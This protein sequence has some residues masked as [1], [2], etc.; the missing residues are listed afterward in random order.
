MQTSK[1]AVYGKLAAGLSLPLLV[2]LGL[3][4][5]PLDIVLHSPQGHFYIV[6]I[7][8]ALSLAL[9]VAIGFAGIRL[10]NQ[11]ISFISLSYVSLAALFLL[12]GLSTPGQLNHHSSVS[13]N[14][15]Q[16]S[17]LLAVV[18][19]WLSSMSS[20][21]PWIR[22]LS[23]WLNWLI[24]IWSIG[25]AV[26]CYLLW[27]NSDMLNVVWLKEEPVKWSITA[28]VIGLNLWTM[29]RYGQTYLKSQFPMQLAIVYSS[30]WMIA[31]QLIIVTGTPWQ[32]SWWLYHLLLL[33]SVAAMASGIF[34]QYLN[35]GSITSSILQLLRGDP[36]EWIRAHMSPAVKELIRTTETRD[37]YTAGHNYRVALYSLRLGEELGLS[38]NQ[39]RAIA[40]GGLVH[41]IGKLV[42]PGVILNKPGKLT[43]E[44]R[45]VIEKHPVTGYNLC[46]RLGFMQ[47][48]LAVIRSHHERW[49]GSG[50]P[51][52][53]AGYAIPLL[54]RVTAVA[55]VY[56]ALTS[57]RSYRKAMTHVEALAH[58]EGESGKHFDPDCVKAMLRLAERQ[59]SFFIETIR[60]STQLK[61]MQSG[62][63]S[64]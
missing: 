29:F 27:H 22:W 12:H 19:L 56:D 61:P 11:K 50:Y 43:Q 32:L 60:T 49:D 8:S 20:D 44:E 58:L 25:I 24:P 64:I 40:Q 45:Q 10:R 28:A 36:E 48:E 16:I 13:S 37:A 9:A 34:R 31:A 23:R 26:I 52:R 30:G 21:R 54:A 33:G 14:A 62:T 1:K 6:S 5:S 47:E 17:I 39:L 57:N 55:D 59:E 53:L 35:T 7:V 3:R 38:P 18:W 4:L 41:D 15:A 51:D 63:S 2:Y 46:R 42:V